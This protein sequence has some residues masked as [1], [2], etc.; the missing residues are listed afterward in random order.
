MAKHKAVVN[1]SATVLPDGM[2]K[3]V[4]GTATYNLDDVG[5]NNRC[6]YYLNSVDTNSQ[7]A[8]PDSVGYLAADAGDEGRVMDSSADKVSFIV[9]KH[10][11]YQG[12]GVTKTATDTK[13][14]FNIESGEAA[15]P[16]A[17]NMYLLPGEVW[18]C[19]LTNNNEMDDVTL[20][21]STGTVNVEVYAC[22]DDA[23]S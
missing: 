14:Y 10:T 2:K 3:T 4:S 11:G 9:L 15:A 22:V 8:I 18:W 7:T 20:E 1:C 23:A 19:R 5:D 6:I 16:A 12:D 21:A 17:D 13:V